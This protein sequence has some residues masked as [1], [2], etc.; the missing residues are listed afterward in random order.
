MLV[1]LSAT[2]A[3]AV[4]QRQGAA[5]E[6]RF[7]SQPKLAREAD[8]FRQRAAAITT[9]EQLLKDRRTLQYVLESYGLESEISKTAVLRKLMTQDPD[10]KGSL[11]GQMTDQ[12]YRQF[13]RDVSNLGR[14]AAI[15]TPDQLLNDPRTLE[16]VLAS[17]GLESEIKKTAVLRQ[18]LTQDPNAAGSLASQPA[19]QRY[20]QF[21]LDFSTA[22]ARSRLFKTPAI[23]TIV[24]RRNQAAY[25]KQLGSDVPGVREALYFQRNSPRATTV[26]QLMSDP[27]LALV[28]RVGLGLPAQFSRLEFDQQRATLE[29]RVDMATFQDPKR[30]DGFLRKFVVRYEQEY[31]GASNSNPLAGL[32][33]GSGGTGGL[34]GVLG[35]RLN[36]RA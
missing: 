6:D 13:A 14:A 12:R 31:G 18:L 19:N 3:W 32:L 5:L 4:V 21:A 25:E 23:E 15:T 27:A 34:F 17:Y 29:Q 26:L 22:T 7:V 11:A 33:S 10:V 35:S 2:T 9:P 36:L 20:K 16:Y 24:D 1:G 30:L 28:L 8:A